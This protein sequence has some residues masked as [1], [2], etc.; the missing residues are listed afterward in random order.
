MR[1]FRIV[2]VLGLGLL[3]LSGCHKKPAENTQPKQSI[4]ASIFAPKCPEV[5]AKAAL[6]D[7]IHNAMLKI[8]GVDEAAAKFTVLQIDATDCKHM[9]VTFRASAAGS[10]SQASPMAYGDD[11]KWYLTLYGKQYAVN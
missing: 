11:G 8:Y 6:Q 10:A 7:G 5:P 3:T 9:T 2:A 1:D 4:V